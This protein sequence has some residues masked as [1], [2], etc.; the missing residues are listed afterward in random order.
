MKYCLPSLIKNHF[1]KDRIFNS[2]T[3]LKHFKF[4]D[5]S[6][7]LKP[8]YKCITNKKKLKANI[9]HNNLLKNSTHKM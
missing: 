2:Y 3:F 4:K 6:K 8:K 1:Y 5:K 7:L 9:I